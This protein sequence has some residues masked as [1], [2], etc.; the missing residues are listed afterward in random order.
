M[1]THL[2]PSA[3]CSSNSSAVFLLR[4]LCSSI[5]CA[6][7]GETPL[8]PLSRVLSPS[9]HTQVEPAF[10]SDLKLRLRRVNALAPITPV[11]RAQVPLADLLGLRGFELEAV[12]GVVSVLR[13]DPVSGGGGRTRL[14]VGGGWAAKL[15]GA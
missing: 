8:E 9:V 2:C 3:Q 12:E 14:C 13:R 4:V 6:A 11:Q 10:L 5:L 15:A 1:S 7:V